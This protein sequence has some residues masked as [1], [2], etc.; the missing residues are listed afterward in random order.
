MTGFR[1]VVFLRGRSPSIPTSCKVGEQKQLNLS[2][3]AA[4]SRLRMP[5]AF[6]LFPALQVG[7]TQGLDF[8]LIA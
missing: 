8:V 7:P 4:S 2:S 5:A 1:T 3:R 6:E